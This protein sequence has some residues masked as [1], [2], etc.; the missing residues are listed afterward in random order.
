[1]N[2]ILIFCPAYITKFGLK[3]ASRPFFGNNACLTVAFP[4]AIFYQ[5]P[6]NKQQLM[7]IFSLI[8][9]ILK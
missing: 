8:Q 5:N 3:G 4:V 6:N 2:F 7:L 1:M 9:W